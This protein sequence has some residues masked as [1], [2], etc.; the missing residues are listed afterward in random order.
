MTVDRPT[1]QSA[2][3]VFLRACRRQSVPHTPVWFMR[4]AGL[5]LPEYRMVRAGTPICTVVLNNSSMAVETRHM[6][7]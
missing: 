1:K 4:Q 2:T 5:S 7:T 6:K 3:A